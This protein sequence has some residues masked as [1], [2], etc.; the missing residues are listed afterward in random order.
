[1]V[2]G[3][4]YNSFMLQ[5]SSI[6][7][8]RSV[9]RTFAGDSKYISWHDPS[10]TYENVKIF[11]EDGALYFQEKVEGI[12]TTSVGGVNDLIT[13]YLE[14][15]LSSTDIFVYVSSFGVSP[16]VFRKT[17]N[18]DEKTRLVI[19]L[20]PPPA[21]SS[22]GMYYNI[23]TAE[24]YVVRS[25]DTPAAALSSYGWPANFITVPLITINQQLNDTKYQINRLAKRLIFQ[26]PTTTF[27]NAN[28]AARIID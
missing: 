13:I 20:T 25:S 2:N 3:R 18:S 6:L 1:M 15:I 21:P 7:K 4:D 26:S 12:T 14:P 8:L 28:S 17:F 27:W 10:T 24:W 19:G 16:S 11:G 22:I 23:I 9:N 5:D